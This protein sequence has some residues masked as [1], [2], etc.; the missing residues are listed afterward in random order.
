[1]TRENLTCL[2]PTHN[3]PSF[4]RRLLCFYTQFSPDCSFLVADSSEN[5]A[6]SENRRA[7]ESCKNELEIEY[8]RCESEG[9]FYGKSVLA[10][11]R[12]RSPFV[13]L[14]ADDDLL[15]PSTLSKCVDFLANQPEYASAMGRTVLLNT[16]RA[17]WRGSLRV[18]KGYSI[19]DEH[20]FSRCRQMATQWF[21]NFYAVARKESLV[22]SFRIAAAAANPKSLPQL[23]EMLLS[24]LSLLSGKAKVLPLMYSVW[25][26]HSSNWGSATCKQIQ[27][28][29]E[30]RYQQFKDILADQ[31]VQVGV[32]RA[33]SEKCIDDWYGHFRFPDL[34]SRRHNRS[35][36]QRV[37]R[38][39][40]GL[41]E[42]VLD[43]IWTE[44]VRHCRSVRASDLVG[45]E[46]TWEAAV[47]LIRDFPHGIADEPARL[48]RCA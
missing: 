35:I 45:C 26:R 27:P 42:R 10:L 19:E 4:L 28:Q 12:I 8:F 38:A 14:C 44:R 37:D 33:E 46:S 41:A 32:S 15:V 39:L 9:G 36:G 22:A 18:L 23:P 6:A 16:S 7:I 20:P 30:Q 25:Q 5:S 24:H 48:E 21:S 1:M 43:S 40:R 13:V 17:S 11:E 3:R 34:S 2:V 29:A 47:K 31:F